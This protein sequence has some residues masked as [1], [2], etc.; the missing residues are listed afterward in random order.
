M[1]LRLQLNHV[2]NMCTSKG[3]NNGH[4]ASDFPNLRV[5]RHGDHT[6]ALGEARL[7]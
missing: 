7:L 1:T 2:L 4:R 6:R 3:M 5:N